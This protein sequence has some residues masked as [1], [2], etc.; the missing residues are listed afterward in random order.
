[1]DAGALFF[2]YC[3]DITRTFPLCGR[4]SKAQCA[5]HDAVW[6]IQR[7][8]LDALKN[9]P[10]KMGFGALNDLAVH[11]TAIELDRLHFKRIERNIG[12]WFPHSI[13][14]HLGLDLHDC[15]LRSRFD[16]K[17]EAGNVITVEPG[18]YIPDDDLDAPAEFRGLAVRIEDD[19]LLTVEG[20]EMLTFVETGS[21]LT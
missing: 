2:G 18:I 14:H 21:F 1:M 3:S 10:G 8:C 9:N 15:P 12:R 4:F 5:I 20:I 19:V 7:G 17:F 13:G 11:F 6:R 16:S